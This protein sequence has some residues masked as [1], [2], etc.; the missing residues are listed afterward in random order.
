VTE[1]VRAAGGIVLRRGPGGTELLLVHRIQY[2][3]W[4][5]PKGKLE[6]GESWAAAALREVEEETGLACLLGRELGHTDYTDSKGRPK[7]ARY[8]AMVAPD[9]EA[10]ATNEVDAVRWA[11]VAEAAERLSYDRD[12]RFVALLAASPDEADVHLVR[13]ALAAD[14]SGWKRPDEERP[15]TAEGR[16]QADELVPLFRSLGFAALVS[17]PYVR[18]VQ[19][20][21]PAADALDLPLQVHEALAEGGETRAALELIGSVALLGSTALSTHGDIQTQVIEAAGVG[22]GEQRKGST[23][24]LDVRAGEIAA[25]RYLPPPA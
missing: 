14:R 2:D 1:I 24:V 10:T 6:P 20:F 11:G 13:H 19:T 5:F 16:R 15:L 21:E 9:A 23:W 18:C 22:E 7:R 12:R 25:G 3:D 4:S 17:S 8:W